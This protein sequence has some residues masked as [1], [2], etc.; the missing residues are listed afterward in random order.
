VPD[1]SGLDP[2]MSGTMFAC[3]IMGEI[4]FPVLIELERRA[5]GSSGQSLFQPT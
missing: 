1:T 4:V 3:L 2:L 5:G